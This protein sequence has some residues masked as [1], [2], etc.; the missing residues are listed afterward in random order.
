MAV[1]VRPARPED[2][3]PVV[4]LVAELACHQGEPTEHFT[5]QVFLRDGFGSQAEFHVFVAEEDGSLLGYA[6]A[7]D[8]YESFYA[9]KG[10]YLNDLYVAGS[11]RRRGVGRT[12]VAAVAHD[13][14]KRGRSYL[15]WVAKPWN[16]EAAA[17]YAAIGARAEPI[18]AHA[19]VFDTFNNLAQEG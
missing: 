19:L 12:L 15:W 16:T 11:A 3:A 5:E 14:Q 17:F 1:I 4:A 9:A 7:R 2:A 6:L 18:I 13:A 8:V 10:V